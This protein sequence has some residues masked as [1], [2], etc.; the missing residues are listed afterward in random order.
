MAK[1]S[2]T[3]PQKEKASSSRPSGDKAPAEPST[4]DYIP[5][6]SSPWMPQAVPDLEDW[7]RKLASTSSYAERARHDLA[8][9]RW[10]AKNNG[11]TK[12]TALRPSSGEEG[13]KSLFPKPGKDKKRKAASRSEGPKPKTRRVRRKAIVLSVASVQ[14]LR[15]EEED[16]EEDQEEEEEEGGASTLVTRSARAIEVTEAPEPMAVVPVGVDP[17]IPSL[18]QNAP[19][20]SLRTMTVG[21]SPSLPTF[22]EEA[23]KE[24]RELKTPDMGGGSSAG[25]P[26]RDC[27]TGVDDAS[28]I[29]EASL[30]LEEAQHFIIRAISRFRVNLSQCKVKLQKVSGERDVMRLLFSPKDKSIKDL[31]AYLAKAHEE[32]AEL[33]KQADVQ[34]RNVKQ[35]GSAQAK[36]IEELE[37][38]LTQAKAEVESSKLLADK[39]VVVYRAD[40][41]ATQMEAREA[42]DTVDTRA[43]WITELAKCRSRRKTLEEIHDRDFD[44]TEEIKKAKEL[45]A[46]A[47]AED[48]ASDSDDDD[49]DG[50]K[51]GSEDGGEPDKETNAPEDDQE[52]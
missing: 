11:V 43:H 37:A 31:Q 14:R 8:K 17:G 16:E 39:S 6:P 10:E 34:L 19:S 44:L 20:D 49:D 23:L 52:A 46:E 27:F 13:T 21:Y 24:A 15:E 26:F 5:G 35:K 18:D 45:E 30:L 32:E 41:E 42:E 29:G 50:S 38:Q 2:K 40:A 48:L 36:R 47:E 4:Y 1:T 22:S 25:D 3:A 7:V 12:D 28:D 9:G 33:N 51:S